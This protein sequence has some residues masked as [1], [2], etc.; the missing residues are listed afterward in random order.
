MF[1][2]VVRAGVIVCSERAC[3]GEKRENKDLNSLPKRGDVNLHR[4][5]HS[6]SPNNR[7]FNTWANYFFL[8]IRVKFIRDKIVIGRKYEIGFL[9]AILY[10]AGSFD[11]NQ[12]TQTIRIFKM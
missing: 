12:Q 1:T 8:T 11:T 5:F 3:G 2:K 6:D 4:T 9:T 10:Q 7:I